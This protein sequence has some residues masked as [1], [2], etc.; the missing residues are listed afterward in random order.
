MK[1]V[2]F[3]RDKALH[4][5]VVEG[6]SVIDLQ[7]VDA[8]LPADLGQW[9]AANDGE[10]EPLGAIAKRAPAS[11]RLPLA[12]LSF[13]LPVARPGKIVCLGLNYLEHAKEGGH[14]KPEFPSIFMRCQTSLTPHLAPIVRPMAS[15]T[16]DYEAE[17]LVVIGRRM[18][19]ATMSDALT[20][21]A[22]Y[23]CF[24]DG[25]IRRFQRRTS[26]WDMGK[27]FDRTGGFGPWVIDA[28]QLP[29]GAKGLKIES[30]L[31]GQVLQS[32][33]TEN[34]V[35]PVAETIVDLTQ[36][37][38]LEP[39]DIIAMGTPSG[40]GHARKPPLW[41]QAG[42]TCEIEIQ[43]IGVLRNPIVDEAV[44]TGRAAAE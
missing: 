39:G 27:N 37:M 17:L 22:G 6:D 18:K 20:C 31:N 40:V 26:Q 29:P 44:A 13:A 11:A 25:S 4:L 9:L 14:Q 42:D 24:N 32:D 33:N 36:A 35:F 30:R 1:I 12:G 19:H 15:E 10:L 5:G 23:S 41:M 34:M 43:G 21:I 7:A 38:T 8:R 28:A 2:G 3:A 16:L